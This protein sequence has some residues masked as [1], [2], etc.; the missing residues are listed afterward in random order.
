[1]E[2]AR[3]ISLLIAYRLLGPARFIRTGVTPDRI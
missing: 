3:T 1:V 2:R